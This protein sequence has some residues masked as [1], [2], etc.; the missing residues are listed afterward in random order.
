MPVFRVPDMTCGHCEASIRQAIQQVEPQ[1]R[2]TVDL[3]RH[4]VR[5]DGASDTDAVWKAMNDAGYSPELQ[6]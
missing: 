2:I 1:A 3:G 4:E 5:V 6:G